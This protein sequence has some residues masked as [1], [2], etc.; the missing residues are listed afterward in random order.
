MR[1]ASKQTDSEQ[2]AEL[3]A[4]P[5]LKEMLVSEG[6]DA[7]RDYLKNCGLNLAP[8]KARI[9]FGDDPE[10]HGNKSLG[11]TAANEAGTSKDSGT[12]RVAFIQVWEI[13]NRYNIQ[14]HIYNEQVR[15]TAPLKELYNLAE[16]SLPEENRAFQ[17]ASIADSLSPA[18][19]VAFVAE[20]KQLGEA[21]HRVAAPR[22]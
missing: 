19:Y 13:E 3:A 4:M 5:Q 17:N 16:K 2:S 20:I 18:Q 21:I 22:R 6:Y 14:V 10:R 15:A 7:I 12:S 9:A 8:S 1:S 11:G